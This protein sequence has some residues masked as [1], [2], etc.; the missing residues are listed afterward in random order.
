MCFSSYLADQLK[1]HV[2]TPVRV[3]VQ[4]RGNMA[5]GRPSTSA[6]LLQAGIKQLKHSRQ[7]TRRAYAT[8]HRARGA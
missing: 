1:R 3:Q 8:G 4:R 5:P 7:V 6:L 2:T